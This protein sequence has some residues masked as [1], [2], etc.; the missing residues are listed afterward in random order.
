MLLIGIPILGGIVAAV[1]A[2]PDILIVV[3]VG[4]VFGVLMT[5]KQIKTKWDKPASRFNGNPPNEKERDDQ[6]DPNLGGP[7]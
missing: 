2:V 6:E 5:T 7:Y 1:I 4:A 3:L